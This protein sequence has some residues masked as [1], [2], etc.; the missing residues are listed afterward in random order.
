VSIEGLTVGDQVFARDLQVPEG[1]RVLLDE[2]AL[3]INVTHA[4]TAE[5]LEEE[6]AEAEAEAG[7]EREEAEVEEVGAEAAAEGEEA[8]GEET[9]GEQPSTEE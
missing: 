5:E 7:I 3:I 2:D 1:S 9:E 6:L 4:P 8:E